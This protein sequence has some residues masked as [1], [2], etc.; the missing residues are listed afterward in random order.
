[1]T[2]ILGCITIIFLI[3]ITY[4]IL[5]EPR[6]KYVPSCQDMELEKARIEI[7]K[8]TKEIGAKLDDMILTLAVKRLV[9]ESGIKY[10]HYE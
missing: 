4:W 9:E 6:N 3:Y 1:M 7:S 10:Y 2:F 5:R 8:N